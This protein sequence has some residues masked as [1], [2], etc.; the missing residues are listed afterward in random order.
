M[1]VSIC[2]LSGRRCCDSFSRCRD[3]NHDSRSE[4]IQSVQTQPQTDSSGPMAFEPTVAP[5]KPVNNDI[6]SEPMPMSCSTDLRA[7]VEGLNFVD[8]DDAIMYD[9][10]QRPRAR[11][12]QESIELRNGTSANY[13][14]RVRIAY[15]FCRLGY[16]YR[17][18]RAKIISDMGSKCRFDN[19]QQEDAAA[20][21]G[22]LMRLGDHDLLEP[23]IDAATLSDGALSEELSVV[24]YSELVANPQE[25]L[26]HLRDKPYKTR[27]NVYELIKFDLPE[28]SSRLAVVHLR[29]TPKNSPDYEHANELADVLQT[30]F[31]N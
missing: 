20:A 12:I 24:L 31:G 18:N 23:V 29:S 10:C 11:L 6:K 14:F 27:K 30:S 2:Y 5:L 15:V 7:C 26:R 22:I 16:R 3:R 9:I 21:L 19:C 8:E 1:Y 13:G 17:E 28:I 4:F 25:L